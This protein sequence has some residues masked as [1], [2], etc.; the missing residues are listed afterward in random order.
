VDRRSDRTNRRVPLASSG[1]ALAFQAPKLSLTARRNRRRW[2]SF[3][4]RLAPS[5]M[6]PSENRRAIC[7]VTLLTLW[8]KPS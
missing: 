4:R 5:K 8:R 1:W 2:S 6:L 7:D 3:R